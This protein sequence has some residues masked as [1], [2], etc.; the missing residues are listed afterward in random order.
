[1]KWTEKAWDAV[2]PLFNKTIRLPFIQ[3][4]MNGTLDRKKFLF[5]LEQDSIY[6]A[7]YGKLL[8]GIATQLK[9]QQKRKEFIAFS[10]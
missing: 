7:S 6:L 10:V 8:T 2:Q 3:E 4:L 9:D 1:M 5:Y